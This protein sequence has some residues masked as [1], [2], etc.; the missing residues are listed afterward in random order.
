MHKQ[1]RT[2]QLNQ[3]TPVTVIIILI[4][5]IRNFSSKQ[6]PSFCIAQGINSECLCHSLN[7]VPANLS[8]MQCLSK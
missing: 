1:V 3:E 4:H 7:C 5:S 2:R 8:K 6:T